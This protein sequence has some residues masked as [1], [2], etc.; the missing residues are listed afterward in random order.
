MLQLTFIPGL[1]RKGALRAMIESVRVDGHLRGQ[2]IG[3]WIIQQAI[4][5]ARDR[6]CKLV[7]LTSDKQRLQAHRFYGSL[8]FFC[9]A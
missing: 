1:S 4:Q 5:V 9:L 2:G 7:Q 3:H 6:G 8:G